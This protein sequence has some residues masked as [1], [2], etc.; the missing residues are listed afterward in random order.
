MPSVW[1]N[2]LT[3][4][5]NLPGNVWFYYGSRYGEYLGVTKQGDPEEFIPAELEQSPASPSGY[6]SVADYY[7][8]KG[9]AARAITD[10]QHA[11]EL[12]PAQ[13]DIR[14][15]LALAYYKQ[16]ARAEAIAQW[17]AGLLLSYNNK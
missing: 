15:R 10:Y 9:D 3:A 5:N 17:K 8:D 6:L 11:L 12:S 7:V 14:D 2:L 1:E 16:N 4:R 13:A